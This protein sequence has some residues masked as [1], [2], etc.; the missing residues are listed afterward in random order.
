[1]QLRPL[2]TCINSYGDLNFPVFPSIKID[3]CEFFS[4]WHLAVIFNIINNQLL[5]PHMNV[6]CIMER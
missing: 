5:S 6:I 1:M 2:Q 4:S 3:Y